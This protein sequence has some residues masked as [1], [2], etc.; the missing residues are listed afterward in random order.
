MSD[1]YYFDDKANRYE[2]RLEER[3]KEL[4]S[5]LRDVTKLCKELVDETGGCDH[6]VGI[7]WCAAFDLIAR[8]EKILGVK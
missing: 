4:G 3:V 1:Y 8:A 5:V 6:S 7:C 2:I